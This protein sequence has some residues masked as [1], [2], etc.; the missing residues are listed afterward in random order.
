MQTPTTPKTTK[1]A[2]GWYA[3]IGTDG[4]RYEA[5]KVEDP[6]RE[7]HGWW[8]LRQVDS[9]GEGGEW[10]ATLPTLKRCKNA[11]A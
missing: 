11:V 6:D 2:A 10:C 7:M 4:L 1:I 5:E 9:L 8:D 3:I